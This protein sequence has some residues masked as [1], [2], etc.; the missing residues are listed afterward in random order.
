MRTCSQHPF[1]AFTFYKNKLDL[2]I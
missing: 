2:K 1:T